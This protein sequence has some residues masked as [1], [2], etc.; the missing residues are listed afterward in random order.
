[1]TKEL[2]DQYENFFASRKNF[3]PQ[4]VF[5]LGL[6]D[7]GSLVFWFETF[8][9]TK[10]VGIDNQQKD[11]RDYFRRYVADRMLGE[12]L[13]TYWG[14]SQADSETL[15]EIVDREFDGP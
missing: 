7:G 6:W 4:N 14:V 1:K 2:S 9:P 12:H 5:E 3:R 15:R 11:D 10:H 13:K 8:R